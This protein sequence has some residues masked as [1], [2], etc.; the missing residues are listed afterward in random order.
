MFKLDMADNKLPKPAWTIAKGTWAHCCLA[1]CLIAQ[2]YV[3][4]SKGVHN[5]LIPHPSFQWE[6]TSYLRGQAPWGLLEA[7]TSALGQ[8]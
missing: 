5:S 8:H 3:P 1:V 7:Q 2:S 4:F 6:L